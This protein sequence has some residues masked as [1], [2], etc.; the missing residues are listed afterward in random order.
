MEGKGKI[1]ETRKPV[2]ERKGFLQIENQS[3]NFIFSD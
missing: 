3:Q 2:L 1:I